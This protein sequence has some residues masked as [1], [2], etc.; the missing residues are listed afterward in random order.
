MPL[1]QASQNPGGGMGVPAG[2]EITIKGPPP[3]KPPEQAQPSKPRTMAPPAPPA[4]Q[5]PGPTPQQQ[6][7]GMPLLPGQPQIQDQNAPGASMIPAAPLDP[8]SMI[9]RL[10]GG[11]AMSPSAPMGVPGTA[12]NG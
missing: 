11:P 1:P 2:H 9:R 8:M 7:P 4:M 10:F 6:N 3:P 12:A 5:A